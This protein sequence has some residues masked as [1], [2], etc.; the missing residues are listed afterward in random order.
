MLSFLKLQKECRKNAERKKGYGVNI[1]NIILCS[2][3]E[4][5]IYDN[6]I[7]PR[8]ITITLT[9]ARHSPF[10]NN[11][12]NETNHFLVC[13]S[14]KIINNNPFVIFAYCIHISPIHL[15]ETRFKTMRLLTLAHGCIIASH[16]HKQGK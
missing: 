4:S 14:A 15:S 3:C 7:K 5:C 2:R 13:F 12:K 11:L 8:P 6:I 9:I 16:N 1:K 10:S